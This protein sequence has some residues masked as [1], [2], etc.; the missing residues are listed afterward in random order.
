MNNETLA[1]GLEVQIGDTPEKNSL[2]PV[3]WNVTKIGRSG[4]VQLDS[5]MLIDGGL[6]KY[7]K[8]TA[9]DL[10]Q[11]D[12]E[13][14]PRTNYVK[15]TKPYQGDVIYDVSYVAFWLKK[16]ILGKLAPQAET[17]EQFKQVWDMLAL[18]CPE[19][20]LTSSDA[21][22]EQLQLLIEEIDIDDNASDSI[23]GSLSHIL[24]TL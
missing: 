8:N 13:V 14:N 9:I 15:R 21:L 20:G 22:K 1:S 11:A 19:L 10:D 7:A 24:D 3:F 4:T 17:T 12:W 5:E 23:Y 18:E 6:I 2:A 16:N